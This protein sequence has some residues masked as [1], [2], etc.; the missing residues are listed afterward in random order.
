M[1]SMLW[2]MLST[3]QG[4]GQRP[5]YSFVPLVVIVLL[6]N[7]AVVQPLSPTGNDYDAYNINTPSRSSIHP[8]LSRDAHPDALRTGMPTLLRAGPFFP[9]PSLQLAQTTQL[10]GTTVDKAVPERVGT[11]GGAVAFVGWFEPV[12]LW[13]NPGYVSLSLSLS[14]SL[15]LSC[16][17]TL[18]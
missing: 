3:L 7:I 15:C 6:L 11:I 12:T 10:K 9:S 13:R 17:L 14:L 5:R 18:S 8:I 16:V 2:W 4:V 1:W